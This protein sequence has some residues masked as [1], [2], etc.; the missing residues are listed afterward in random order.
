MSGG[1]ISV[2][3]RKQNCSDSLNP[4]FL[5]AY[6]SAFLKKITVNE[7][8]HLHGWDVNKCLAEF[9]KEFPENLFGMKWKVHKIT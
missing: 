4:L 7:N 5:W 3:R 1:T 2:I 9:L 6:D 8:P